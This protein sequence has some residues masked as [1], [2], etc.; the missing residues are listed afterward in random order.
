MN[1]LRILAPLVM[2]L[3]SISFA[4]DT[5]IGTV[6]T[7]DLNDQVVQASG[8]QKVQKK[9]RVIHTSL[10]FRSDSP[11]GRKDWD[12][13]YFLTR[14]SSPATRKFKLVAVSGRL[15]EIDTS[16]LDV[17]LVVFQINGTD[18][19]L[20]EIPVRGNSVRSRRQKLEISLRQQP[21]ILQPSE[22]YL[23]YSFRAKVMPEE[24]IYRLYATHGGE[25]L[26]LRRTKGAWSFVTSQHLPYVFPFTI[27]F[28]EG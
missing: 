22:F 2:V 18:T 20:R 15:K 24:L 17:N 5:A 3:P 26:L 27:S 13:T 28:L 7:V 14:F 25:G 8:L 11:G 1:P 16:L 4:Q 6:R 12:S 19:M 9:S 10:V 21:I 23:G